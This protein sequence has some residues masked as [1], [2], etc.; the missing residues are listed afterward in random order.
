MSFHAIDLPIFS[1]FMGGV[2]ASPQ[3]TFMV[4]YGSSSEMAVQ[5]IDEKANILFSM[6]LWPPSRNTYRVYKYDSLE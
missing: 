3:G 6:S 4:S 1:Q 2:Y 5:E